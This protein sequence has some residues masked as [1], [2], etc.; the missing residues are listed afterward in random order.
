MNGP[1][2]GPDKPERR[3]SHRATLLKAPNPNHNN[4]TAYNAAPI[5]GQAA[6][7]QIGAYSLLNWE[8][9]A[10]P[11]SG[12]IGIATVQLPSGQLG[13]FAVYDLA[14]QFAEW[15]PTSRCGGFIDVITPNSVLHA[16]LAL[17]WYGSTIP[18]LFEATV[19]ACFLSRQ[20]PGRWPDDHPQNRRK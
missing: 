4:E 18:R 1:R 15:W 5:G 8:R 17:R 9:C 10:P 3:P 11:C 20:A 19:A 7:A 6:L 16:R 14:K 12:R 13:G 2:W